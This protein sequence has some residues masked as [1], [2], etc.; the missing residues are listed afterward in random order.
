MSNNFELHKIFGTGQ[1]GLAVMRELTARGKTV[2]MINR[3]GQAI[4]RFLC[5]LLIPLFTSYIL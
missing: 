2:R 3:H 5:F 1:L 4:G